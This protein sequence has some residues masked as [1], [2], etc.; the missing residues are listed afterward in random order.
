MEW[1]LAVLFLDSNED[2]RLSESDCKESEKS[3]DVKD[4][5][6]VN[7]D[8]YVLQQS[9]GPID[10][11]KH[12]VKH[13]S[14][15]AELRSS[16]LAMIQEIYPDQYWLH[17]FTDGSATASFGSAGEL[18]FSPILLILKYLLEPELEERS[19]FNGSHP[20][21]AFMEMNKM[22]KEASTLHPVCLIMPLRN[23]SDFSGTNFV[24][25]Q[26]PLLQSWQILVSSAQWPK[27]CSDFC[28]TWGVACFRV[29]AT[30]DY[31]QVHLFK[32]GLAYS[33]LCPLCKSVPMT[34]EH[35]SDCSTELHV[36]S[37]N[38]CGVLPPAGATSAL[39]WTARHLMSERTLA[40]RKCTQYNRALRHTSSVGCLESFCSTFAVA[41]PRVCSNSWD[42]QL[43]I[44]ND[45][46][47]ARLETNLGIGQ[48]KEG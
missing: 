45:P 7:P 42:A 46:R 10:F 22:A 13:N 30:H 26:H 11:M 32:I 25:K 24:R 17:V 6:P 2:I 19:F 20:I 23:A 33:L 14:V 12:N 38:N 1:R 40:G 34:G 21:T 43:A 36:L 29:T 47:Y 44:P 31:L 4:N 39:Y 28:P 27:M 9:S 41:L 48:A 18:T 15:L 35:L 37:Q 5:I 3:A 16:A 8:I